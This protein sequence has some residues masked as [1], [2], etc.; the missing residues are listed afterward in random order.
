MAGMVYREPG[1]EAVEVQRLPTP[2]RPWSGVLRILWR[3]LFGGQRRCAHEQQY[4]KTDY[5]GTT[6]FWRKCRSGADPRCVGGL[7][8]ECCKSVCAGKCGL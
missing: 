3:F 2:R 7:C 4:S 6:L 8:G 5:S 1:K